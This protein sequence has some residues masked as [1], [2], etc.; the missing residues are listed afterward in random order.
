VSFFLFVV[1]VA[2]GA[3]KRV[4]CLA[5]GE[6]NGGAFT[7]FYIPALT[8]SS[9]PQQAMRHVACRCCRNSGMCIARQMSSSVEDL[10]LKIAARCF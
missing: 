1:S 5:R 3:R 4:S 9:L 10:W 8:S 7:G 6:R 2:G